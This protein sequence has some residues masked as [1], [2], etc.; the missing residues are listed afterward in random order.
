MTKPRQAKVI[1]TVS[2]A[3]RET[4]WGWIWG[5][6]GWAS[7]RLRARRDGFE[8]K[9]MMLSRQ[10]E[11]LD[12]GM[13]SAALAIADEDVVPIN[14]TSFFLILFC[15]ALYLALSSFASL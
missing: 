6:T 8:W 10:G 11:Q 14:Q 15:L 3:K 7:G 12:G 5:A 2:A 1:D 4:G 13:R 9:T